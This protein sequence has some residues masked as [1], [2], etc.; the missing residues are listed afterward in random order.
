[1]KAT[2]LAVVRPRAVAER[3]LSTD[4]RP[5]GATADTDDRRRHREGDTPLLPGCAR[6]SK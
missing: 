1:M 4:E 5:E 2:E 6:K 3:P